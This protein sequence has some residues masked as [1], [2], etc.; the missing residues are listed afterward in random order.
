M[1]LGTMNF[2]AIVY[3]I[4]GVGGVGTC[5]S[6]SLSN[7][8]EGMMSPKDILGDVSDRT[9]IADVTKRQR[10]NRG[11]EVSTGARFIAR[12]GP[13]LIARAVFGTGDINPLPI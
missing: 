13:L 12:A 9:L 4:V 6:R 11:I 7:G 5:V 8:A 10:K 2:A 3:V 1:I